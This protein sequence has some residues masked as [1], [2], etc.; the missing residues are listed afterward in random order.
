MNFHNYYEE[1][2]INVIKILNDI[3]GT[4]VY[5]SPESN[6]LNS[7]KEDLERQKKENSSLIDEIRRSNNGHQYSDRRKNS[8]ECHSVDSSQL[9]RIESDIKNIDKTEKNDKKVKCEL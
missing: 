1:L 9:K 8:C 6:S 4:Y 5:R 7:L 3:A 2:R